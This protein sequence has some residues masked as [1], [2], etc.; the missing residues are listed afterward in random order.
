MT[1]ELGLRLVG[2]IVCT[3]LG[4]R[5]GVQLADVT[6]RIDL[7][8]LVF[9]LVG[10]IFGLIITPYVTTRPARY[11]RRQILTQPSETLLLSL[12]GLGV[13][14]LMAA[15]LSVPLALLPA[16]LGQW[17]PAIVAITLSYIMV[18]LFAN[19][20]SD[21]A[22]ILARAQI[23]SIGG[24][25]MLFGEQSQPTPQIL[26]DTSVIIDGRVLDIS[27]SGFLLGTLVVP[28][29]VLAELQHIADSAE[30]IKRARGRRGLEVLDQL[31]KESSVPVK[32][33]D[34][35]VESV[36]EV[37]DKLV[38]LARQLNA[39][40]MTNDFNLNGIAK[41]QGVPVM[42]INDLANAVK[43]VYL[44]NERITIHVIQE[45]REPNQGVG[46]LADGTMVV[47][48]DGKKFMDR[49]LEVTIN[50]MIQTAAGKMYFARPNSP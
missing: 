45:G 36:R 27:K 12:I 20:A 4:A 30:P 41:L 43:A 2:M 17:L 33:I 28:R 47:V 32:I 49:T 35:D 42:N 26:L 8:A 6:G 40:L 31:Q 24:A 7:F 29:F 10:S 11:A 39:Q 3:V 19:R 18:T 37:D 34:T 15:L 21:V 48:E 38:L 50:R 22:A 5:L 1:W 14:L 23:R 16:P 46:Y 13:G 9:G 25:P 44:P